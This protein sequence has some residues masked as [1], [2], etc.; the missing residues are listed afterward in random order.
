MSSWQIRRKVRSWSERAHSPLHPSIMA[1]LQIGGW[2]SR[3]G[4]CKKGCD[5]YEETHETVLSYSPTDEKGCGVRW[6]HVSSD[7]VGEAAE[8]AVKIMR[9]DLI[10]V[11]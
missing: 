6:T 5:P 10:Y 2:S 11:G 8:N 4:E 7:Y 9:P 1:T 3:C